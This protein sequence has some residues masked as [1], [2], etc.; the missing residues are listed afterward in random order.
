MSLRWLAVLA[1]VL[2]APATGFAQAKKAP[3]LPPHALEKFS[4]ALKSFLI[5]TMPATLYDKEHNWGHQEMAPR[6]KGLRVVRELR[7]DGTWQKVHVTTH[8]LAHGLELNVHDMHN[9][10]HDR[11]AFKTFLA[12]PTR[13]EME[14]QVWESGHRLY[15][16]SIRARLRIKLDLDLEN[17]IKLD[18]KGG[19]FPDLLFRLKVVNAKVSYDNLVVEHIGGLGGTAAKLTGETLRSALKQWKPSLERDMLAKASAAILKAGDTRDIRLG[20][21][22]LTGGSKK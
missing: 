18:Y 19:L 7:N 22:S 1:L 6:L 10:G 17:T 16:G 21:S 12:L 2:F 20:L 14:E 3:L 15:S 5:Q 8:D 13:V 4:E 11:I 9:K